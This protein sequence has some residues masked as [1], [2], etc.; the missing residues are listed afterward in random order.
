[1]KLDNL[2]K[3]NDMTRK[4][5]QLVADVMKSYIGSDD[6]VHICRSLASEFA[7]I[8]SRFDRAKFMQACGYNVTESN[9]GYYQLS[10]IDRPVTGATYLMQ[11]TE[12]TED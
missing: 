2:V 3:G 10:E 4:H 12:P 6:H 1:M 8:N 9:D 7:E 11:L 5:F